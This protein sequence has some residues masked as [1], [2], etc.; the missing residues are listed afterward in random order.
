MR[1][2][3]MFAEGKPLGPKGLNWLKLHLVNLTGF[4]KR[5]SV[6]DRLKYA[7]EIM[8]DI[9]DSADHPFTGRKYVSY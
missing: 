2:C 6:A 1:G 7:E 5:Q 8:S 3:L 4:L 9:L